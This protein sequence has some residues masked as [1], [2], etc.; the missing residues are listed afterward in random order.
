[1][2]LLSIPLL[3]VAFAAATQVFMANA[4]DNVI[5][6]LAQAEKSETA[7][8]T[9][10]ST[11]SPGL[12]VDTHNFD[13]SIRPHD[14]F[15]RSINGSWLQNTEIPADKSNYGAFTELADKAE[16]DQRAIIEVA[17]QAYLDIG[18]LAV[19]ATGESKANATQQSP[20]LAKIGRFYASFMNVKRV[21]HLGLQPLQQK[22]KAIQVLRTPEDLVSYI[23]ANQRI[24]VAKPIAYYINQDA[25]HSTEYIGY[26][27]QNG[28]GLPDR[29]YYLEESE[30][31][32]NVRAKYV[33]YVETLLAL[34]GD[35]DAKAKAA[36]V[37]ALE[38]RFAEAS[39]T[40]IQ[41]RDREKKYNK[42]TI[43]NVQKFMPNFAWLRFLE[44]AGV[45]NSERIIISQPSY[46]QAVVLALRDVPVSEWQAYFK[47]HLLDEY[48]PY[49][50][51]EFVAT[52]FDFHGKT[53]S[54][55]EENRPRWKRGVQ[56]VNAAMGEAVGK[57]YV[58]RHFSPEAKARMDELVANLSKAFAIS[59]DRL[60]W[61]SAETKKEAHDK[62][63]LFTP[64]IGYPKKWK[65]YSTLPVDEKDL[66]GNV[67]RSNALE[68]RRMVGKL[69]KPV[70]RDEWFM[71]PQTVN[72]YYNPSMN[73][74]VFPAAI[75]QPPFFNVDADDAVNYGAIV[76]VI[77]HE[78]SHGFDDQG[79]KSDG[80]GDLRDW[81]TES[82]KEE[83]K[84][85]AQGLIAQYDAY[86]P[87]EEAHVKGELTLGENIADL[88]GLTMAHR[89]YKLSLD[90][91]APPVIDGFSGDQR[92]FMG[93]AQVWRRKYREEELRKRL[94]T[95][96]HA[97]SEYRVNGVL[98]NMPQFYEAY[99]LKEE[100]G[101]YLLPDKR[102]SIW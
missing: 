49:L 26:L 37:M 58:E 25:R 16:A 14:N 73:E 24:G 44:T 29:D 71:T 41:N 89:A 39:W 32:K 11:A 22:L 4:N 60:D 72:A 90:G 27:A 101:M 97:P 86:S 45:A 83:F 82:D 47:F 15:Y 96:P 88:A 85:R 48:A 69:G 87:L 6:R 74:V 31:F 51:A 62:L 63:A 70:D 18:N 94:L 7:K 30:R 23:G 20:E 34:A 53:L 75:L 100:D 84:K 52:H 65:N 9:L 92:F 98:P 67:L 19:T 102:L 55:T 77:G 40:N 35:S 54:G 61:M 2:K 76:A 56:V 59:I 95:D 10:S 12:G 5:T 46:M 57:I 78:F 79:S 13:A 80:V 17:A 21:E 42:F 93:W 91:V 68:Y 99:N 66:V 81:W 8:P 64:K 28:L 36:S 50:N 38:T 1:M 43:E 33:E 3:S